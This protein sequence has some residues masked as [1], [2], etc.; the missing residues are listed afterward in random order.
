MPKFNVTRNVPLNAEQVF[1]VAADVGKYN[2]FV[3]LV[4][5]AEISNQKTLPDGRTEFD[6]ALTIVYKKLGIS[7]V[8]TS[9]VTVDKANLTVTAKSSEGMVTHMLTEWKVIPLQP[10]GCDVQFSVDYTLRSR[11]LQFLMSGLFDLMVRKI[12]TAFYERARKL[13]AGSDAAA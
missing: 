5:K 13:Y 7:D 4:R 1:A 9:H 6:S 8:F 2:E 11:S 10:S 3:P 12:M